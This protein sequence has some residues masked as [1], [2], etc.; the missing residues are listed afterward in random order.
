MICIGCDFVRLRCRAGLALTCLLVGACESGITPFVDGGVGRELVILGDAQLGLR[1]GQTVELGVRY[2]LDDGG[3]EPVRGPVRFS[4]FGDPGGSTLS[5][6]TVPTDGTGDAKATLTAGSQEGAGFS[7]HASAAGA[8]DAVFDVSVSK[9]EFVT[10]DAVLTDPLPPPGTRS[11]VAALFAGK[12][13]AD[14]PVTPQLVG[15]S[16]D[17]GPVPTSTSTLTFRN[18]LSGTYALVGRLESMDALVAYGCIDLAAALLPPGTHLFVPLALVPSSPDATGSFTLTTSLAAARDSRHDARFASVDIV[19]RCPGHAAQLL[20]DV[21]VGDVDAARQALIDAH[22]GAAAPSTAGMST[23][24]C[25]SALVGTDASLDVQLGTLLELAPTGGVRSALIGDLDAILKSGTLTSTLRLSPTLAHIE[26]TTATG[27]RYEATHTALAVAFSLG[28]AIDLAA[29]GV[30][31]RVAYGVAATALASRL[32]IGPHVLGL[33]LPKL[34]SQTFSTASI[35]PRLPAL[36]DAT[37]SGWLRATVGEVQHDGKT[38]CAAI[39]DLVCEQ[40][41]ATGCAGTLVAACDDAVTRV[42]DALETTFV[43]DAGIGLSGNA[44]LVDSNADLVAEMLASGTFF[45]TGPID[46]AL[47][48]SGTRTK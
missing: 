1:Y 11:F 28:A 41:G 7:V 30:P 27:Q 20:L 35:A 32:F 36:T 33:G 24:S 40:S 38:G 16:R 6:D 37:W 34:W 25:R 42:G 2:V 29:L 4:I 26:D 21:L 43:G 44:R 15:A 8:A 3:Q 46:D 47:V 39:E 5:R 23:V 9:L 18:L 45:A 48:F 22:R 14:V 10:I 19:D 12:T 13:C 17:V 31:A